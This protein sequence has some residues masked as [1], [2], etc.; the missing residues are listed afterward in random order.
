MQL[1]LAATVYSKNVEAIAD[2]LVKYFGFT[3]FVEATG[4]NGKMYRVEMKRGRD[5]IELV[6][7]ANVTDGVSPADIVLVVD[8]VDPLCERFL[9][10]GI[11]HQ[12]EE[13]CIVFM[14]SSLT[15]EP[16]PFCMFSIEEESPKQN[17]PPA[18]RHS[19]PPKS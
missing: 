15:D 14:K 1:R 11:K 4:T 19:R 12:R 2:W 3:A 5:E 13:R 16:S 17:G 6:Y 9:A 10:D 18:K 8:N 7:A